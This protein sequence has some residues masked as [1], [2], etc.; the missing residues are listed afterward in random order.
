MRYPD[1]YPWEWETPRE[2]LLNRR[3]DRMRPWQLPNLPKGKLGRGFILK[4]WYRR[5]MWS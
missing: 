2:R 4:L 1:P 5:R 3:L